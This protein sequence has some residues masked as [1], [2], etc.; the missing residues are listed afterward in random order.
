MVAEVLAF[1]VEGV[2]AVR[3][4]LAALTTMPDTVKG[5]KPGH[6]TQMVQVPTLRVVPLAVSTTVTSAPGMIA[7]DAS[8]TV[9]KIVPRSD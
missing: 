7:P 3:V 9:P 1:S 5:R 4:L 6:S 8:G 2:R